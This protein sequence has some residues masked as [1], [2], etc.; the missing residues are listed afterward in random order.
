[1]IDLHNHILPGI[2]DG[3]KTMEESIDIVKKAVNV[4]VTDI[5]VTPH[6]I[7]NSSYE[8]E[9]E[10]EKELLYKLQEEL[11]REKVEVNL[12]L[13][14]EVFVENN[15]LDLLKEN[16]FATLNNSRYLLF[17]LPM[18]NYYRGINEL[19]FKLKSNGIIPV[20]AHPE[21]Y[22]YV[23]KN[24]NL[25]IDLLARGALLQLDVGSLY[26]KHG[27]YAKSTFKLLV[28]HHAMSLIATDTHHSKDTLYD[29]FAKSVKDL[30]KLISKEE[31]HRI[32]YENPRKIIENSEISQLDT[33]P[34]KKTIFN[35]WK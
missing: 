6:F 12:Y 3:A 10:K 4:G 29:N 27:K 33:T 9:L 2:D 26:G 7:L 21:R 1:M 34:I 20:I 5:I 17:E 25:A 11:K 30:E 22:L 23:Q 18:N 31:I 19:L 28:K 15:L 24:P 8:T 13:G 14:N 35:R 16:R 32:I